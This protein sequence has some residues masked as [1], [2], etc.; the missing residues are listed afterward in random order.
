MAK[1]AALQP[2]AVADE[3]RRL[4]VASRFRSMYVMYSSFS[5]WAALGR[6][7]AKRRSQEKVE[8][9]KIEASLKVWCNPLLQD[10]LILH[11]EAQPVAGGGS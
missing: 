9:E 10:L 5:A 8:R 6:D 11:P 2:S 4:Q 3:E 7:G 1:A